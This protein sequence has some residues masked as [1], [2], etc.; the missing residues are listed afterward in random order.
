[1]QHI[2]PWVNINLLVEGM[3]SMCCICLLGWGGVGSG[4]MDEGRESTLSDNL[5]KYCFHVASSIY[6]PKQVHSYSLRLLSSMIKFYRFHHPIARTPK[7]WHQACKWTRI[8]KS[9][10]PALSISNGLQIFSNLHK[11]NPQTLF[12]H[13][14]TSSHLLGCRSPD[15]TKIE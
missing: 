10:A 7:P 12:S 1:M 6:K 14:T 5:S 3:R 11:C 2:K 8:G 15:H 13:S 9:M 4:K